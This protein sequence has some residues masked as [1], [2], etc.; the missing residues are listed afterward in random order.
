MN[1]MNPRPAQWIIVDDGYVPICSTYLPIWATYIRREP[2]KNDEKMT[3]SLNMLEGMKHVKYDSLIFIED[4]DY[5][6]SAYISTMFTN[7][8]NYEAY[9][10]GW[11]RFFQLSTNAYYE[12]HQPMETVTASM[13]LNG[14]NSIEFWRKNCERYIDGNGLDTYFWRDFEGNKHI[15]KDK[16]NMSIG[17]KAWGVGRGGGYAPSHVTMQG[18]KSDNTRS[19]LREWIGN[20]DLAWYNKENVNPM[21]KFLIYSPPYKNS[22][23][24]IRVLYKLNDMLNALGHQSS[25]SNNLS[26]TVDSETIAIYPEIVI[27]NPFNAKRIVRYLLNH[28]T[29]LGGDGKYGKDDILITF[30]KKWAKYADNQMLTISVVEDFFRYVC[31]HRC[32]QS[33]FYVGKG[34]N[35]NSPYTKDSIEIT[36]TFPDN[37]QDLADMLK[38]THTLYSYDD[39]TMLFEEAQLAGCETWIIDGDKLVKPEIRLDCSKTNLQLETLIS[40]CVIPPYKTMVDNTFTMIVAYRNDAK[41]TYRISNLKALLRYYSTICGNIVI[42]EQ[43]KQSTIGELIGE[44]SIKGCN[45]HNI[46]VYNDGL[47][48]KSWAF[49]VGVD[50]CRKNN[51]PKVYM[52]CDVDIF[53][54]RNAIQKSVAML[55]DNS[56]LVAINPYSKIWHL[57]KYNSEQFVK[58]FDFRV[59]ERTSPVESAGNIVYAGGCVF[60]TDQCLLEIN[61]WDEEYRG[62]GAEDNAMGTII[63]RKFGTRRALEVN[64]GIALHLYHGTNGV[65][66]MAHDNYTTNKNRFHAMLKMSVHQ[67]VDGRRNEPIADINKYN[68][69]ER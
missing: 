6:P 53:V 32:N 34:K 46:F 36:K 61:G 69:E 68:T 35:T 10:A 55:N 3:L 28:P 40:R 8:Q 5:Y 12:F 42:I 49:N 41:D 67:F 39:N 13:I 63:I 57:D 50:Y 25:I 47:F 7:S 58:D 65:S 23:A 44:L 56:N 62:W 48:N 45:I 26:A 21:L 22:S 37:R 2:S 59:T 1:R 16:I 31:G 66:K 9:G 17:I 52:F 43:D 20:D 14:K 38:R 19:K 4:D 33:C 24:G 11:K 51:L 15:H 29:V 30:D 18:F 60:I 27:G 54:N 64:D